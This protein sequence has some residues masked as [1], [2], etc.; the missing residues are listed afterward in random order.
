M[1]CKFAVAA[2]ILCVASAF[3]QTASDLETKYGK[4]VKNAYSVSE[5]V[6]MEPE[7]ASDGKVCR[8][9]LYPKGIPT[10]PNHEFVALPFEEVKDTLNQLVPLNARG[11]RQG[12]FGII[13]TT[14]GGV[15]WMDYPYEN[16][17]FTF[18]FLYRVDDLSWKEPNIP[19]FSMRDYYSDKRMNDTMP[20][21]DDFSPVQLY[22]GDKVIIEW[23]DRKCDGK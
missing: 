17:K 12:S 2:L 5:H 8:M 7:Y 14:G 13:D 10:N 3:G 6:L 21:E 4:P 19:K 11:A 1:R 18:Y 15:A 16:V 20:A 22:K 9:R 23:K